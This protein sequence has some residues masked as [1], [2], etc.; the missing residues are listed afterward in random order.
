MKIEAGKL[1]LEDRFE[2]YVT[3]AVN[4]DISHLRSGGVKDRDSYPNAVKINENR[5]DAIEKIVLIKNQGLSGSNKDIR[6]SRQKIKDVVQV[7]IEINEYKFVFED[8]NDQ[9][10]FLYVI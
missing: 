9:L 5:L 6:A 3:K 10:V 1:L 4:N 7:V 8:V 2:K